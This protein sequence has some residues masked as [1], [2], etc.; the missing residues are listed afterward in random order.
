MLVKI[1]CSDNVHFVRVARDGQLDGSAEQG[2]AWETFEMEECTDQRF[3]LR[4]L[5]SHPEPQKF[6]RAVGGGGGALIADR[7]VANDHEKFTKLALSSGKSA[8][9]TSKGNYWRAKGGGGGE[10]DAKSEEQFAWEV[11]HIEE[12]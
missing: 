4:T 5:S 6:V 1:R 3:T 12:C 2:G 7:A 8:I 9:Q 11:F 10:L